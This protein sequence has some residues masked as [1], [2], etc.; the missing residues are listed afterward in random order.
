MSLGSTAASYMAVR[1]GWSIT[2]QW[3]AK[4]CSARVIILIHYKIRP[5][6]FWIVTVP[7]TIMYSQHNCTKKC[8]GW[9]F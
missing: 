2:G 4:L 1:T 6:N 8:I 5:S 7:G 3:W 9:K